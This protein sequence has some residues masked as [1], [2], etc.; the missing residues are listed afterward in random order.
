MTMRNA[1]AAL[2]AATA[3]VAAGCASDEDAQPTAPNDE[4]TTP[5]ANPSDPPAAEAATSSTALANAE[6]LID[7]FYSFDQA[8]LDE[9]LGSSPSAPFMRYYQGWAEGASYDIVE[10]MPCE[11]AS[12]GV[13]TCSIT[14]D[15]DFVNAMGIERDTTDTFRIEVGDDGTLGTITLKSD[16]TPEFTRVMDTVL[17]ENPGLFEPGEP[18]QGL[19]DDGPTPGD[20][21]RAVVE[22]LVARA[23]G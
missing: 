12:P 3:L 9:A 15:D 11:V 21:A 2:F 14:V 13:V 1:F 8:L 10:R 5:D 20:C 23:A 4:S 7:A 18:C 22:L 17:R 6:R 19:F 16:D